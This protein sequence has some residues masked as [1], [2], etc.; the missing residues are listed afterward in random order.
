MAVQ[1][2]RTTTT[3][4]VSEA[5]FLRKR[6]GNAATALKITGFWSAFFLWS[7]FPLGSALSTGFLLLTAGIASLIAARLR[8][9]QRWAVL[10]AA[11]WLVAFAAEMAF[12]AYPKSIRSGITPYTI[13]GLIM[14]LLP[15]YFLARGIIAY[16]LFHIRSRSPSPLDPLALDPYEEG[17]GLKERPRFINKSSIAAHLLLFLS[18]LPFVLVW[19]SQLANAQ[20]YNSYA[21]MLGAVTAQFLMFLGIAVLGVRIYR[22]ARRV[23]MLPG[24]A[25]MK[26]D[27]RPIILY[28]RSFHDDSGIRLRA[29]ATNGRIL[30]ERL[31]RIPFEEVVTDHLWS[32][33]PVLA[34]GNPHIKSKSATLGAARD[35][36]DEA[37]WQKKVMD[38]M[39]AAAMIVLVAGPSEGGLGWELDTVTKLGFI[40]KFVI[41]LPPV[42]VE[43]RQARWKSVAKHIPDDALPRDIDFKRLRAVMFLDDRPALIMGTKGDDWTY[44]AVLDEAALVIRRERD[45]VPQ[46]APSPQ[47]VSSTR[48]REAWRSFRSDLGRIVK[49]ALLVAFVAIVNIGVTARNAMVHPYAREGSQRDSFI[50]EIMEV[51]KRDNPNLQ[52][53]QL[54][55]YCACFTN[56]LADTATFAEVAPFGDDMEPFQKRMRTVANTCT[57]QT[58]G[59]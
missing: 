47:A 46:A 29:R 41:L 1:E 4:D 35:Y 5:A 19:L 14:M 22:R 40:G 10:A 7:K 28:L 9:G 51:C 39:H 8:S 21:E 12:D 56:T 6:L 18:P 23:A 11:A 38:H 2:A 57:T 13:G 25:L 49:A 17:H 26:K 45:A 20:L 27:T 53:E 31:L 32:Y 42:G 50:S 52:V 59:Q 30:P 43:E 37:D 55:R 54:A 16:A 58:L 44:E 48:R 33:G 15:L 36:L 3:F 24:S 34:I